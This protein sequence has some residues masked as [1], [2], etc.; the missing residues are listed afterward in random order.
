MSQEKQF[1]ETIE[2]AYTNG[3]LLFF[4]AFVEPHGFPNGM[5]LWEEL[6]SYDK[7]V[8]C[9][10]ALAFLEMAGYIERRKF[11]ERDKEYELLKEL[12]ESRMEPE[13][14]A[15]QKHIDDIRS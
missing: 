9:V 6:P 14:E 10:S 2:R 13:K 15:L 7:Y 8:Y 4:H 1:P 3:R 5:P 11:E 12:I